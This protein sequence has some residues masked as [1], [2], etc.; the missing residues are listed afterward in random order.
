MK[1]SIKAALSLCLAAALVLCSGAALAGCSVPAASVSLQE[2]TLAITVGSEETLTASVAP[3][4]TTDEL[5]WS[6]S[7]PA[8]ATV[9]EGTVTGVGA[10]EAVITAAAGEASASCTVTVYERP[11]GYTYASCAIEGLEEGYADLFDTI[12]GGSL[13]W[14]SGGTFYVQVGETIYDYAYTEKNGEYLLDAEGFVGNIL[15]DEARIAV[16]KSEV[17]GLGLLMITMVTPDASVV[18]VFNESGGVDWIPPAEEEKPVQRYAFAACT[19]DDAAMR[20]RYEAAFAGAEAYFTESAF[21]VEFS[22]RTERYACTRLNDRYLIEFDAD[23]GGQ[24]LL[25]TYGTLAGDTLVLTVVSA[26]Q[27]DTVVL[28]FMKK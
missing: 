19:A 16:K 12:Y 18:M 1:R 8:V 27:A 28:T 11:D 7:D 5:V 25:I 10:G 9:S 21:C 14:F 22:D 20:E 2:S 24:E 3:S 17:F 15:G 13:A 26:E 23:I 4:D 6:S